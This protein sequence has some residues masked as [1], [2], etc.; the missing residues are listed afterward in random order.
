MINAGLAVFKLVDVIV[1]DSCNISFLYW[2]V[3]SV[4]GPNSG[5]SYDKKYI[6]DKDDVLPVLII[7]GVEEIVPTPNNVSLTD[8]CN[9]SFLLIELSN[10]KISVF[11][12]S[13]N[14]F[15]SFCLVWFLYFFSWIEVYFPNTSSNN[16]LFSK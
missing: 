11:L 14:K 5:L 10:P 16:I 8:S 9:I 12:F 4:L 3:L 7:N 15:D 2:P 1:V 6:L 13:L